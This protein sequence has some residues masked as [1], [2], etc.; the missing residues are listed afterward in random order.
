MF[1]KDLT[2]SFLLDFYGEVLS[3]RKR[4]VLDYYYNDDLS[5]GEIAEE[6][7][8]SRQGVRD[9]IKKAEEELHFY[10]EKLGLAARFSRAQESSAELLRLLDSAGIEGEIYRAA[11]ELAET[12]R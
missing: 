6:I 10:E 9:L 5:L 11:Q 8:I 3:E 2:I 7:G 4:T 1:E 12:V